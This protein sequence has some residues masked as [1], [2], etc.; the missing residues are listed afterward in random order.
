MAPYHFRCNGAVILALAVLVALCK[1]A[2]AI[3]AL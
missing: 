2:S 3:L 1:L